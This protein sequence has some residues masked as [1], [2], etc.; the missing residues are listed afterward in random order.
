M[1][2]A[3]I[4]IM[5]RLPRE[6]SREIGV[7]IG[8]TLWRAKPAERERMIDRIG[9]ALAI[10]EKD[11]R[12]IAHRCIGT[13]GGYLADALRL[14]VMTPA[15]LASMVRLDGAGHLRAAVACGHGA[16]ALSAHVG[17]W[18]VLAAALAREVPFAV[19][20]RR[21]SDPVLAG[22]LARLR[23]RWG[24]RTIW[25]DEGPRPVLR[26]LTEGYAV[27]VLIDQATTAAGAYVPFFGRPAH[28]PTGPARIALRTGAPVVPVHMEDLP[29]GGYRG[30]VE[31]PLDGTPSPN[32][33]GG[34]ALA[35][36]ATWTRHIEGWVRRAPHTW[37]WMHDR[38][39][40]MPA[41][42]T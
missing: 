30:V 33:S 18:E 42:S 35:L 6:A 14:E 29:G 10:P 8:E 25:R 11:A 24:I 21:P 9:S 13:I 5:N 12:E 16:F 7:A 32:M 20:A 31:Q 34:D 22:R 36:T 19:I 39:R 15:D 3:G 26:A 27:G 28:T 17:N 4:A 37:V 41:E 2:L 1:A 23:G 38:W 40:T